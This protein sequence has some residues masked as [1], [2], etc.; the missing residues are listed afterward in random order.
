[1]PYHLVRLVIAFLLLLSSISILVALEVTAMEVLKVDNVPH[2][3]A[4]ETDG[5]R[6]LRFPSV[7][8][9]VKLYMSNWYAPPCP[10]NYI[11]VNRTNAISLTI[12]EVSS[13]KQVANNQEGRTLL[14]KSEVAMD[15]IFFLDRHTPWN[16]TQHA[17]MI[18]RSY[19]QDVQST[20]LP[21]LERVDDDAMSPVFLQ[22]G[23]T[24]DSGKI[25]GSVNIPH[26]RK[27]RSVTT[28]AR[29]SNVTLNHCY[30]GP[31]DPLHTKHDK[32]HFQP[33]IWKLNAARHYGMLSQ[34]QQNDMPW[35]LKKNMTVF[36][37]ALTGIARDG[38]K[39]DAT[40]FDNCMIVRRCRLV[41]RHD[42]SNLVDARLANTNGV[43]PDTLNGTKLTGQLLSTE[44][45][46][47]YKAIIMLE[48]NDVASGLKWALLSNS[49]VMMQPPS[50]TS[51]AMEELLEPWVHYI[52]LNEELSDVE[53]KMQWVLDH[54]DQAQQIAERG[55]L[56]IQDLVLHSDAVN[57][58]KQIEEEI[59]RRYRAHFIVDDESIWSHQTQ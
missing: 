12:Q 28:Q 34:V 14:F 10:G 25:Y 4:S 54:D 26:I 20:L 35:S 23:D 50:Y 21:T 40:A 46:L 3:Q 18:V 27:I 33:I 45:Q 13:K 6:S 7:E 52:P 30:N 9:R 55:T 1:M 51:W 11:Q 17:R 39:R 37:G 15:N 43:F 2:R 16:C 5:D 59:L 42:E 44:Q 49:V 8:D 48:G 22:F 36:R 29:L 57:D 53:E 31:R 32:K 56:W 41:L 47:H 24:K 19:C 38:Y 58:D